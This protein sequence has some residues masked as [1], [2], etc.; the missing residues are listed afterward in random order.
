MTDAARSGAHPLATLQE[1]GGSADETGTRLGQALFL[2]MVGVILIITLLPFQFSW[3]SRWRVMFTGGAVDIIANV[4]LFVPLGF[5]FRLARRNDAR[6]SALAV[7][8]VGAAGS[9]AIEVAQLFEAERYSSVLDVATNAI[10]ACAGA[11]LLDRLSAKLR[12]DGALI[13]RLSLELPLMGL[14]YLLVPLLWLNALASGA[15]LERALFAVLLGV[16]GASVLGG[17]Q[18]H[19]F[20]PAGALGARGMALG[21][22]AW[23]LAGAFPGLLLHP[24]IFS[25]VTVGVGAL[26][27]W[28]GSR[29]LKASSLNR[30]FE[31]PVL[32]SAAPA[33]AAYLA[34]LTVAPL[35]D[36]TGR[37]GAGI[38]FP[39]VATEW[40]KIEIL[41][42]LE[43]VAAS[44]MLGYMVAEFRGRVTGSFRE[45]LARL[46]GWGV[47]AAL[48]GE[49]VRG[50][51]AG[52]GASAARALV[53]A[54]ATVYGG[55]LYFLQR[56]HVVR[57]TGSRG[58]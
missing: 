5:L 43:L 27:W 1:V 13:G 16:F 11:M 41:R 44:T 50:W 36:G 32:R 20:A 4:L 24:A 48:L 14:I 47:G 46:T 54:M 28:K 35:L 18:R 55:W 49:L 40:T 10:G 29:P 9:M 26:A 7:L 58:V 38:G 17:L 19:H 42:F 25:G 3:P 15:Q 21:A 39:G 52:H 53:I 51:H 30:R 56:D 31:V 45:S 57:L 2:Y 6:H 33:Y 23:F 12:V 37:W 22:A 8:G 34:L